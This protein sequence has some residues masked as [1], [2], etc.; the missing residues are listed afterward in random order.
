[1]GRLLGPADYGILVVLLGIIE[2]Y[3]IPSEAIGNIITKY[4]SKLNLSNNKEELR[5]LLS[6]S[7]KKGIK[8]SFILFLITLVIGLFLS[9]I[10]SINL[11]IILTLNLIS[12]SLILNPILKG[13]LQG[14]K[15]FTRLGINFIFEGFAKLILSIFLVLMGFK[16]WGAIGGILTSAFAGLILSFYFNKDIIKEK[17][18]ETKFDKIYLKGISYFIVSIVLLLVFNIDIFI[19]KI[20]F[21]PETTGLYAVLSV[22][23]KICFFGTISISK[24]MFP[25]T[26]E[27]KERGENPRSLLL[28]SILITILICACVFSLF[29]FFPEIIIKTLYGLEYI[30]IAPLLIYS[31][32][33]MTILAISNLIL[34]YGLSTDS[35]KNSACL[36]ILPIIEI[37]ILV[38][39]HG[40]LIEYLFA[41]IFFNIIML[42]A[43]I[44]FFIK[45]E[46][47]K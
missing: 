40:S 18:K 14:R 32:I 30:K 24:A 46:K 8:Y 44:L 47:K 2:I 41:L 26:S 23:G 21:S 3:G 4:T 6:K 16:I 43:T 34:L 10:L 45:W 7:L 37:V 25:L 38:I 39:Y 1:M 31:S 33:A 35:L 20:F 19:A 36:F 17:P 29:F 22:L 27:K 42:I 9:K 15:K 28:K 5:Y 12:F 11:W 13:F